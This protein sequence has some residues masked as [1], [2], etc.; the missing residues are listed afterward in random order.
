MYMCAWGETRKDVDR[1]RSQA[2]GQALFLFFTSYSSAFSYFLQ[3][4]YS[5]WY[6]ELSLRGE[7]EGWF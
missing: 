4:K 6:C 5:F 2:R 1:R 3:H 7:V